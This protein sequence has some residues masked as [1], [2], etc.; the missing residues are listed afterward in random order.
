MTLT[1]SNCII[2]W[3]RKNPLNIQ[4]HQ[5]LNSADQD[6]LQHYPDYYV[7]TSMS[8]K[9][10][11]RRSI[12]DT[13]Q[14]TEQYLN[15][16]LQNNELQRNLNVQHLVKQFTSKSFD[17]EQVIFTELKPLINNFVKID[18]IVSN[19]IA[20]LNGA[21]SNDFSTYVLDIY[22]TLELLRKRKLSSALRSVLILHKDR[23]NLDIQ[24]V[25]RKLKCKDYELKI[26]CHRELTQSYN[27][28]W[29][30]YTDSYLKEDNVLNLETL[31][32]EFEYLVSSRTECRI[33]MPI[34]AEIRYSHI[35]NENN[36][37][38]RQKRDDNLNCHA[39]NRCCLSVSTI[40]ADELGLKGLIVFPDVFKIGRCIG[41]C[42]IRSQSIRSHI[43][44]S[45][46][47]YRFKNNQCCSIASMDRVDV[48]LDW[49]G[50]V[51]MESVETGARRCECIG[52]ILDDD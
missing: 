35:K 20:C 30:S 6:N 40:N 39:G 21:S 11:L 26:F 17:N 19:H 49:N 48:F 34:F 15:D 25:R 46:A 14:I 38:R 36:Y 16:K 12:L 18:N 50:T 4:E 13:F 22:S 24:I 3:D 42:Y 1:S 44:R 31:Q 5:N 2:N 45:L 37:V 9:Y 51:L 29:I 43:N 8:L 7:H 27:L 32:S 33:K 41:H 47:E 28:G 10:R 52:R 23:D